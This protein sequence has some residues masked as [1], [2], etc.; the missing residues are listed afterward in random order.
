MSL[1]E[2]GWKGYG[3]PD[4]KLTLRH[5]PDKRTAEAVLIHEW[6]AEVAEYRLNYTGVLPELTKYLAG[7]GAQPWTK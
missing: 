3:R 5:V 6:H 4:H 7:I 2:K 1:P